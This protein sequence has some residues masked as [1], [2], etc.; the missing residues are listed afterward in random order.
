MEQNWSN[1][2]CSK[3]SDI[4]VSDDGR[5]DIGCVASH[6]NFFFNQTTGHYSFG[7]E[8]K[9]ATAFLFKPISQL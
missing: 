9:P 8:N 5:L 6:G 4:E 1:K 3:Y 7:N 2:R